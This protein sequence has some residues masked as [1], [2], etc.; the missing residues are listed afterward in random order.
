MKP[1][2]HEL[3]LKAFGSE[4][5]DAVERRVRVEPD[6]KRFEE[7]LNGRLDENLAQQIEFPAEAIEGAND[8]YVKIYPGAFSQV[9]EGLDGIFQMPYG[10]FEQTSS[11]TYPNILVLDYMRRNKQ[12]KPEVEI[13][14]LNFINIG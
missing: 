10:C 9:V 14:A 6:G 7:I 11:A 3:P 4:L 5:A 1:G 2:S 13:K 8:L 12:I